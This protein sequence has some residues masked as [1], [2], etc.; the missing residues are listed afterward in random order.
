MQLQCNKCLRH[1]P[2]EN[3]DL[4]L[5]ASCNKDA[6]DDDPLYREAKAMFLDMQ[7]RQGVCCPICGREVDKTFD[8]H[9]KA[10]REGYADQWAR[11][12][13]ITLLT[14]VR[15][16]LALDRKCHEWVEANPAESKR[17]GFTLSASGILRSPISTE[18]EGDILREYRNT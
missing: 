14:D 15:H 18:D 16:F 7:I 8:I 1:V 3:K 2:I 5:C 13:G 10:G 4:G 11:E 12:L 6:R 17:R 9:H